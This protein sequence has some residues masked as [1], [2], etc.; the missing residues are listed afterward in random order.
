[1][2]PL[3]VNVF[4]Q[5]KELRF[6]AV[7][8]IEIGFTLSASIGKSISETPLKLYIILDK[9][10]NMNGNPINQFK[11]GM[12]HML[13]KLT[14][15]D[16]VCIITFDDELTTDLFGLVQLT[17]ENKKNVLGRI[18]SIVTST[19]SGKPN[20][21][22]GLI[23]TIDKIKMD[24][25]FSNNCISSILILTNGIPND[26]H[27][28]LL[29]FIDNMNKIL[30]VGVDINTIGYSVKHNSNLLHGLASH[31]K[32]GIYYFVDEFNGQQNVVS[33]MN[34][35]ISRLRNTK[36]NNVIIKLEA[37]DGCRITGIQSGYQ[38]NITDHKSENGSKKYTMHFGNISIGTNISSILKLSLRKM[39]QVMQ[40]KL[41]KFIVQYDDIES[42]M[43]KSFE[44]SIIVNRTEKTDI[45]LKSPEIV[46]NEF[47]FEAINAL[48]NAL[49]N[50]KYL[51]FGLAQEYFYD[52]IERLRNYQYEDRCKN[53]L[54][55]LNS[56][57]WT[58]GYADIGAN[59]KYIIQYMYSYMMM[60]SRERSTG[61]W[62]AP[63]LESLLI[64]S[65]MFD[66]QPN[67]IKIS[68]MRSKDYGYIFEWNK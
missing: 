1:M 32:S 59:I 48:N 26:Y 46:W 68:S 30:P 56:C 47:R 13:N 33:I 38:W 65:K 10:V 28:D 17:Q 18:E 37:Q 34:E 16:S 55:D 29:K 66:M 6:N 53:L 4:N 35:Y 42:G 49:Q 9:S 61:L 3:S 19:T 67:T 23:M 27:E 50:I 63:T 2:D 20:L 51:Q 54:D 57:C 43:S 25:Q 5:P 12:F 7:S 52:I 8:N 21:Y 45:V 11:T 22:D 40:H 41:L 31:S 58:I 36:V 24:S 14:D 15:R 60:Y 62:N 64:S 39:S 44:E